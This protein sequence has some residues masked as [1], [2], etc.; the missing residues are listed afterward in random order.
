MAKGGNT[1][2]NRGG[3]FE[4]NS[5]KIPLALSSE[6]PVFLHTFVAPARLLDISVRLVNVGTGAATAWKVRRATGATVVT[7]GGTQV[8]G[9]DG[10][11][12]TAN[13]IAE[14]LAGGTAGTSAEILAA[15]RDFA[16][17]DQLGVFVTMDGGTANAAV[18]IIQGFYRGH[19]GVYSTA[20]GTRIPNEID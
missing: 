20:G 1:G 10:G 2:P 4:F 19:S 11:A 14:A 13:A 6:T 15:Q 12:I 16:I 18:V 3:Y 17:G 8:L 9:A 5:G 7:S